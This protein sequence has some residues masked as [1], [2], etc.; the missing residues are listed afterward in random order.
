LDQ[1]TIEMIWD[2]GWRPREY[3][4]GELVLSHVDREALLSEGI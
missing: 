4:D 1:A 3:D 2:L